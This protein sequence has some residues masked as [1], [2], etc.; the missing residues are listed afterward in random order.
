M[1][2]YRPPSSWPWIVATI[3]LAASSIILSITLLFTTTSSSPVPVTPRFSI[4][5]KRPVRVLSQP[6]SSASPQTIQSETA[7]VTA[8]ATTPSWG[9]PASLPDIPTHVQSFPISHLPQIP[10]TSRATSPSNLSGSH[11][12]ISAAGNA[13]SP[14]SAATI[15]SSMASSSSTIS[16]PETALPIGP[17]Q[18]IPAALANPDPSYSPEKQ[19]TAEALADDFYNSVSDL[20]PDDPAFTARW[21]AE[22]R[23]SDD[24]YRLYYGKDAFIQ[25]HISAYLEAQANSQTP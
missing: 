4:E 18:T 22:Q 15:P 23:R 5:E 24:L 16:S 25:H 9:T 2:S 7:S 12:Q 14:V 1:N 8:S 19:A 3:L 17:A 21:N 6:I 10:P 13:S 11:R 20:S